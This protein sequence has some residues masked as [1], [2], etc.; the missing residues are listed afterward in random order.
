MNCVGKQRPAQASFALEL[1][2]CRDISADVFCETVGARGPDGFAGNGRRH[3]T[4]GVTASFH[5]F[6]SCQDM[7]DSIQT[8]TERI[9]A[10]SDARGWYKDGRVTKRGL[11]IS[12]SLEAAELLEHFQWVPE[13]QIETL[14]QEKRQDLIDE[15]A[16]VAIYLLQFA[17]RVGFDLGHAIEEKM[18]KNAQKYPV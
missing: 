14:V 6:L 11:A 13:E 1:T 5:F 16:D 3:E 2:L 9:R 17:D 10:F 8:L 4:P 7:S 12:L 18:K 15:A